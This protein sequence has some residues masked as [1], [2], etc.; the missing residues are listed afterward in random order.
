MPSSRSSHSSPI[1]SCLACRSVRREGR[2]WLSEQ[3][4]PEDERLAIDRHLREF[5]RLDG[6]LHL[7]E[8]DFA[9]STVEDEGVKRLTPILGPDM[10]VALVMKAA[11][12]DVPR[13][14]EPQKLVSYLGLNPGVGQS[15]S[16]RPAM[17]R[18][19]SR[20][21]VMLAACSSRRPVLPARCEPSA[22]AGTARTA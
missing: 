18:S 17:G 14:D 13:F 7:I 19:P 15:G 16:I 3:I 10:A 6:N 4:V 5:D 22:R 2:S 9:R 8:R 1:P 11:A 12:G 21:V 20:A